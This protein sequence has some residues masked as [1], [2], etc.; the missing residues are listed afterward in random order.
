M[1]RQRRSAYARALQQRDDRPADPIVLRL[2]AD[3]QATRRVQ[4]RLPATIALSAR[5]FERLA[6]KNLMEY[7][8]TLDCDPLPVDPFEKAA[9]CKR[10]LQN[11]QDPERWLVLSKLRELWIAISNER[12]PMPDSELAN[13]IERLGRLQSEFMGVSSAKPQ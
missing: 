9:D 3:L 10:A 7:L 8:M 12:R 5:L 6:W 1:S 11:S 4:D 13:H 2:F